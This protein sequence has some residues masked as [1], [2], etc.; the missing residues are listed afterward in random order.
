MVSWC[1]V[2]PLLAVASRVPAS[3]TAK[4]RVAVRQPASYRVCVVP[5]CS[6]CQV[7]V[8]GQ[9]EVQAAQLTIATRAST[10]ASMVLIVTVLPLRVGVCQPLNAQPPAP[11]AAIMS[12]ISRAVR[13]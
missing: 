11:S 13:L 5:L 8:V 6:V 7:G 12:E 1:Q 9:A 4:Q 2:R 10:V 3:P